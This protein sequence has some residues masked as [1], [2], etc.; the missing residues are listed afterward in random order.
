MQK[1]IL[2]TNV[3]ISSLIAKG[4]PYK[5]INE[6]VIEQKINVCLSEEIK[7]EYFGVINREKFSTFKDF[8]FKCKDTY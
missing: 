4:I 2:D 8:P 3:L 5:I 7:E 6:L 1:T